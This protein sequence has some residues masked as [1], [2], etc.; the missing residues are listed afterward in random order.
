MTSSHSS[1]V[2]RQT[3]RPFLSLLEDVDVKDQPAHLLFEFLDLLVFQGLR[4]WGGTRRSQ[5]L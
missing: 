1:D 2:S 3:G 4:P 5:P